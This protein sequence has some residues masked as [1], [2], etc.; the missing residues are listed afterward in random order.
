M[1]NFRIFVISADGHATSR[2]SLWCT[3][4]ADAKEWAKRL[5]DH[6]DLELWHRDKR[7]AIFHHEKQ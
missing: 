2:V 4:E 6:H 1:Q 5:L 3:D 7:I